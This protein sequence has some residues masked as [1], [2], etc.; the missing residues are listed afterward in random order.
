MTAEVERDRPPAGLEEQLRD[1]AA[2]RTR[3]DRA[4]GEHRVREDHGPEDA[5]AA[6]LLELRAQPP[7]VG[8]AN[9]EALGGGVHAAHHG[10]KLVA[11]DGERSTRRLMR[12][13]ARRLAERLR[14]LFPLVAFP[15]AIGA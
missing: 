15:N 11:R 8:G 1:A 4:V 3:E 7:T 5:T 10:G 12:K 13:R 2:A 6:R 9:L 14:A